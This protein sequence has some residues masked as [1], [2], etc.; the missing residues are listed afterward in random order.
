MWRCAPCLPLDCGA[1]AAQASTEGERTLAGYKAQ[2][3]L[4][5]EQL[6]LLV[7]GC[8]ARQQSLICEGEQLLMSNLMQH[9]LQHC[10]HACSAD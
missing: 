1:A 9:P 10:W 4:L 6:E 5:A 8:E 7:A 2:C 3:E